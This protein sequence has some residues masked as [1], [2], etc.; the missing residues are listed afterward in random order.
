M[1]DAQAR[2][3]GAVTVE[4]E[5]GYDPARRVTGR[6]RHALTNTDCRLLLAEDSPADLHDSHGGATTRLAQALA[7]PVPQL[8]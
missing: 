8:C 4:S 6:K 3:T 1:F 5:R 2:R 7:G